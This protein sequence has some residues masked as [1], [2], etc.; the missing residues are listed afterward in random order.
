MPVMQMGHSA[1]F[2]QPKTHSTRPHGLR[3]SDGGRKTTEDT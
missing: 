2:L 1:A 3:V